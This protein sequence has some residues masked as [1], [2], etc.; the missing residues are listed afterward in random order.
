MPSAASAPISE[1]AESAAIVNAA[2]AL[3]VKA[4][5]S[6]EKVTEPSPETVEAS[7]E[8]SVP[9]AQTTS[10]LNASAT[11]S[12]AV[13]DASLNTAQ[14]VTAQ[15]AHALT[16]AVREVSTRREARSVRLRLH[17]E[18]L[19]EVQISV[20]I[21]GKGR[22]SAQ[23][24]AEHDLTRRAIAGGLDHLRDHLGRAGVDLTSLDINLSQQAGT[25]TGTPS[26]T[27]SQQEIT[28]AAAAANATVSSETSAG[29]DQ[30]STEEERLLSLRA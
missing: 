23:I 15:I 1:V 5:A 19:G 17:P 22:L 8:E 20:T 12:A 30:P 26:N 25:E 28:R 6:I 16:E 24:T 10:A 14:T 9:A 2:P 3:K 7:P 11:S 27:S 21:D 4:T 29:D 18:E 13:R